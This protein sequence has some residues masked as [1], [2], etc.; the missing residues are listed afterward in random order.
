ML[1][2]EFL[3]A[4]IGLDTAENEPSK[5]AGAGVLLQL[6]EQA[7]TAGPGAGAA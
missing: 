4:K 7:M 5:S 1:Q 2:S 3:V 6:P